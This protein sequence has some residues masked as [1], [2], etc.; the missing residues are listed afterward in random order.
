M[1]RHWVTA[2]AMAVLLAAGAPLAAAQGQGEVASD[3]IRCWWKTAATAVGVGERFALLLTCGV[4]ETK[5]VTVVPSV[6]QLQPGA[7]TL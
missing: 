4:I 5:T 1:D 3:P 2:A 7:R 6:N